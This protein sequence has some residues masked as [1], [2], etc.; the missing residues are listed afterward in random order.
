MSM[1]NRLKLA[2]FSM[3]LCVGMSA[4]GA[5]VTE[6]FDSN[7][8]LYWIGVN[9]RLTPQNYGWSDTNHTG[10]ANG[11]LGGTFARQATQAASGDYGFDIGS[12]VAAG[13]DP[14]ILTASGVFRT[15]AGGSGNVRVGFYNAAVHDSGG[16]DSRNHI[17]FSVTDGHLVTPI[18][19]RPDNEQRGNV[20]DFAAS[21]G[22]TI[23]WEF[24]FDQ[25]NGRMTGSFNGVTFTN[26]DAEGNPW[27]EMGSDYYRPEEGGPSTFDR[28]GVFP[29][30]GGGASEV[31]LDDITF[32]SDNPIPEPASLSLLAMGALATLRRRRRRA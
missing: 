25:A 23:P 4:F 16:S 22:N 8:D 26:S 5:T 11:E 3:A 32:T 24:T 29:I 12:F 15:V 28:F 6:N 1:G 31:Y 7:T 14:L 21:V 27:V 13:D 10:G 17:G 9:N 30:T 19:S 20:I 18:F 2:A